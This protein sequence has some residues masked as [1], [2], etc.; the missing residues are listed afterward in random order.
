LFPLHTASIVLIRDHHL[1]EL[2]VSICKLGVKGA[3]RVFL[4]TKKYLTHNTDEQRPRRP[5]LRNWYCCP[6][7]AV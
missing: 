6:L 7:R 2:Q 4:G 3:G 1:S 5:E